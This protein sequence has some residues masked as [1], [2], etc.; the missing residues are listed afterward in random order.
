MTDELKPELKPEFEQEIKKSKVPGFR[1]GKA[2]KKVVA[3]IG[4]IFIGLFLIGIFIPT[5]DSTTGN[6]S[7]TPAVEQKDPLEASQEAYAVGVEQYNNQSYDPALDFLSKVIPDDPNYEDAQTKIKEV[8]TIQ[9]NNHLASA[10]SSLET[11]SFEA[12]LAEVDNA[13]KLNPDMQEAIALK[14]E[15]GT[16]QQEYEK[17][18]KQQEIADFKNSCEVMNYKVL[19]KNP[20]ALAGR[21][22]KL[23]GQIMQIQEDAGQTFM[24]L[25]ITDLGY[26]VW[27]DEVAVFYD[28]TA[29]VYEED[30]ITI[31]GTV[32]GK[33]EYESVAGWNL[34]VPGVLA[35]YVE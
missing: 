22:V 27:T 28:G 17:K 34:A 2:W 19:N 4:Y 11:N 18:K 7:N 30:V 16:K 32:S 9:A 25:S 31:W 14:S 26:G 8:K 5:D 24:L 29:D 21:N 3:V 15:I 35:M 10:K 23:R 20:D 6:N 12:A 13:L 33:F 1:S